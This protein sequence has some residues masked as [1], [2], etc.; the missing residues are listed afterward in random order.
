M[1]PDADPLARVPPEANAVAVGPRTGADLDAVIAAGREVCREIGRPP[2][3]RV[4]RAK[5][6]GG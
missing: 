6:A 3:S 1:P 5:L 4:S 2:A